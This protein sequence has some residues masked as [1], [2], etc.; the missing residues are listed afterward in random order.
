MQSIVEEALERA[1]QEETN[2]DD[3]VRVDPRIVIV[4]C[5]GAGSNSIH[6]LQN[7]G[8]EK[9]ETVAI[10]TDRQ[11]LQTVNA[12]TKL[13]IGTELTEG[14]GTGGDPSVG[15]RAAEAARDTLS[16]ILDET[17]LVFVTAGMGGG[18]GT[19][20]AP[21][22]SKVAKQQG[23]IVVGMVSTPF[24]V[25][26]ARADKAQNGLNQL[27]NEADSIIVLDNNKLLDYVADLP[28]EKAFSV[29]DQIIAEAIKGI[30]ETI[31]EPSLINLDYADIT[32]IVN[33]GGIAAMH[34]GEAHNT[35]TAEDIAQQTIENPLI[36]ID[37]QQA[38]GVLVHITGGSDLALMD[39]EQIVSEIT[40]NTDSAGR[41]IWGARVREEYEDKVRVIAIMSGIHPPQLRETEM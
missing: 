17:D 8:I 12:D 37:Y 29:M 23:A 10:N 24:D 3:E 7:I 13:L 25:E 9:A 15:K 6:R 19:G 1:E 2:I 4:G 14:R 34:I 36:N 27:Q 20:A 38:S 32:S 40:A 22:V 5:G 21:V 30:S 16:E 18:T 35:G 41:V 28:L 39:A 31:T 26:R 33:Q 11:H